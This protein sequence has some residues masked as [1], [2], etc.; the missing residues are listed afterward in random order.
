VV[1]GVSELIVF[2]ETQFS[3]LFCLVTV[4]H[5]CHCRL[6]INKVANQQRAVDRERDLWIWHGLYMLPLQAS[7]RNRRPPPT[8]SR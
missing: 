2:C 4:V 8:H 3:A 6:A 7:P 1:F 5:R